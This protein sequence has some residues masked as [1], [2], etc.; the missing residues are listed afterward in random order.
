MEPPQKVFVKR[1]GESMAVAE[2][3]RM[4]E[5]Q[6]QERNLK[7]REFLS[8]FKDGNKKVRNTKDACSE[9]QT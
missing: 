9:P 3:T 8:R 2:K 7:H 4:E 1:V 5:L 6:E